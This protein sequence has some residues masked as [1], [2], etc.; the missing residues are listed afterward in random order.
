MNNKYKIVK[1]CYVFVY[2]FLSFPV[3]A[4]Q[5]VGTRIKIMYSLLMHART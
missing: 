5:H 4:T 3:M 1:L 2:V